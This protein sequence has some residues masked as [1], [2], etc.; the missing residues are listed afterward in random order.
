MLLSCGAEP[1]MD[2]KTDSHRNH[3]LE[4][5]FCFLFFCEIFLFACL[6]TFL[7]KPFA[8]CKSA[9]WCQFL[10]GNYLKKLYEEAVCYLVPEGGGTYL[11]LCR[12]T[13]NKMNKQMQIE[14]QL[15]T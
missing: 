8:C 13:V 7:W 15:P 3:A 12:A 5:E 9:K 6:V 11:D 2:M 14:N 1:L 10:H 4:L